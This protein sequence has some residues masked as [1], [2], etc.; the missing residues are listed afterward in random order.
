VSGGLC[1]EQA[2]VDLDYDV[3]CAVVAIV[4]GPSEKLQPCGVITGFTAGVAP[5]L[6]RGLE[7]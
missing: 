4:D 1:N 2:S 7:P 6:G 5:F 3:P